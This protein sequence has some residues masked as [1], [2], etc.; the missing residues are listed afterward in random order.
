MTKGGLKISEQGRPFP[1]SEPGFLRMGLENSL[2]SLGVEQVDLYLVHAPDP[3]VPFADTAEF[4]REQLDKGAVA[5]VGVSNFS[6]EQAAELGAM[7]PIE[8]FESRYHIFRR[9][10]EQTVLPYA[11]KNDLGVLAYSPLANGLLSGA[12]HAGTT[13]PEGD[14]RRYAP[15]FQPDA[16]TP[17]ATL[18]GRLSELARDRFGVPVAQLAMAW[19]LHHP[20]VHSVISGTRRAEHVEAA[21]AA[22]ELRLG[23]DDLAAIDRVLDSNEPA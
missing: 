8:V 11:E 22:T 19:S 14:W 2:R 4:L 18:V 7:V 16:L 13:F 17:I 10:I 1:C 6:P 23:P 21:V 15:H 9:E 3:Q 12:V 5:H 20:A